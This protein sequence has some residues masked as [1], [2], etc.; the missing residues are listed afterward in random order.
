MSVDTAI[1]HKTFKELIDTVGS[2]FI[3]ELVSAYLEETP[4]L[5]EQL[6]AAWDRR[7][8][9]TFRRAAHSIKSSSASLGALH[10]S[11]QARA[12]EVQGMQAQLDG[13]GDA[14]DVLEAEYARAAQAFQERLA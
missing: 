1:D 3:G 6:R 12:L 5:L 4:T 11:A 9:E 10:L 2:D 13:A 14:L 7:D 8:A